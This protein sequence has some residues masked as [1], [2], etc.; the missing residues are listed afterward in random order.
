MKILL[1]TQYFYPE[2]FRSND[3]A[4]E[5][6]KR[7]HDVTVLC[8]I[9]NYPEGKYFKDYGVFK[10]R[11]ER[12][13]GVKI[14]RCFQSARGRKAKGIFLS[15]NY[16]TYVFFGILWAIYLSI[17]KRFDCVIVHA[18]SPITQ[19]IPGIVVKKLQKIPLYIWVLDIWPNAMVSGGGINNKRILSMMTALVK[20]IYDNASQILISS[21]GFEELIINQA[22]RF[23]EKLVYFPNWADDMLT[24]PHQSIPKLPEGYK[25]MMAGNLGQAQSIRK[26]MDA[27]LL[28][29]DYK[30]IKWIFVGDGSEKAY[31]DEFVIKHRLQETVFA[32]GRYPSSYMRSFFDEADALLI[33]LRAKFPHIR[34]VIPARLQS[35]MSAGKPI[36]GMADGAVAELIEESDCGICVPAEDYQSLSVTVCNQLMFN[37]KEFNKKGLNGRRYYEKIFTKEICINNLEKILSND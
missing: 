17:R 19:A 36:I 8:G 18:P 25:I 21:K 30:D 26:V 13:D 20:W 16:L 4:F 15:L 34:A 33:T 14:Y 28:T 6:A 27:A 1:V 9:P 2:N 35:Y 12:I 24:Q 32:V 10:N 22:D 11:I 3:I 31:I 37:F 5:L 23:K 7:G 29:K